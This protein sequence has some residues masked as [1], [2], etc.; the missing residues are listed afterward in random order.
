MHQRP[1]RP[2]HT[3][4]AIR[5]SAINTWLELD[6]ERP[7]RLLFV[8]TMGC[9]LKPTGAQAFRWQQQLPDGT[10]QPAPAADVAPAHWV[11]H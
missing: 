6:I 2:V 5:E 10:L 7:L 1:L 3:T 4:A 9:S 11:L 8:T